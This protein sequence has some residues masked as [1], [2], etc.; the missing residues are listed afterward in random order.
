MSDNAPSRRAAPCVTAGCDPHVRTQR[1][2]GH[3]ST[4][5]WG[6]T[7][8]TLHLSATLDSALVPRI[9]LKFRSCIAQ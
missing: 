4:L 9:G 1:R 6:V 5:L 2:G 8:E 7:C 3:V